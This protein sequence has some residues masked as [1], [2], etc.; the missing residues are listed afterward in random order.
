VFSLLLDN[1]IRW[2]DKNLEDF[3]FLMSFTAESPRSRE[4]I[5]HTGNKLRDL[6]WFRSPIVGYVAAFLL[7]GL[8]LLIEKIDESLE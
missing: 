7:V 2:R 8:L 3:E 6:V 1:R 5:Q 4:R